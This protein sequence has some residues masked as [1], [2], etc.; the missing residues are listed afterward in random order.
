LTNAELSISTIV[1][2]YTLDRWADLSA[3][4]D[5]IRAQ[6]PAPA[7]LIV[8]VDHNDDLARRVAQTWP[9]LRVEASGGPPGLSGARNTGVDAARGDIVAFLDDD[10]RAEPGWLA[11]LVQPYR[12]D[13]VVA[14]GGWAV[15]AWDGG[16]PGWFPAEFDWV[17]GCSHLGLPTE[18]SAVR[19]PIGCNMSFR[20][21]AVLAA[22]GFRP[23]VGRVGG[24]PVGGEE[25]EL[26][27]RIRR[28]RPDDTVV[29]VPGAR[30]RHRVPSR[31]ATWAY[32]RARCYQE[33]RSKAL[34]S[35]LAGAGP[36]LA[37]ERRYTAR[38]LP[39]GVLRG[40][41]ATA[42]GDVSGLRRAITIVAGL[43]VT[44]SGFVA[45]RIGLDPLPGQRA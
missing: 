42:R 33:G 3:A 15:A 11:A 44:T 30:V 2:A 35:K 24:F 22:G 23:E 31:R 14:T 43:A 7:E 28:S 19:N 6:R 8:V 38:V 34:I 39:A 4:V 16:R 13:R 27:I 12:D 26:C 17:V 5:S 32:F 1:C 36:A 21:A 29:L 41:A 45:A 10:A 9:D 20:R 18:V 40:L 37:S 25:T